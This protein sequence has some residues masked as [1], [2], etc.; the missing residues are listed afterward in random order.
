MRYETVEEFLA[1]GG[2]ITY[3][4]SASTPIPE[5][6]NGYIIRGDNTPRKKHT[7]RS[8]S[9][10]RRIQKQMENFARQRREWLP[11]ENTRI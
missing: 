5:Y 6:V 7:E 9:E 11:S 1:R 4:D 3:V 8:K 10:Y 2:K